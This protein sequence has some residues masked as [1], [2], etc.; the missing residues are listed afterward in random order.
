MSKTFSYIKYDE[1]T[2]QQSEEA[3][4]TCE[5]LESQ[6]KE[7]GQGRY[8]SLALTHLEIAYAMIGKALRDNQIAKNES[9]TAHL[10][11]R[12]DS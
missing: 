8:Q 2:T 6:I 1:K 4:A 11:E 5:K 12:D 10:P 3:K 9:E 7:L